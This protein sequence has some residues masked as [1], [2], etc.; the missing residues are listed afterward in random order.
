MIGETYCCLMFCCPI[1]WEEINKNGKSELNINLVVIFE[2]YLVKKLPQRDILEKCF[3]L[4]QILA[5]LTK[6][7]TRSVLS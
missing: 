3:L 6:G 4:F 2:F 7:N 5:L 1:F